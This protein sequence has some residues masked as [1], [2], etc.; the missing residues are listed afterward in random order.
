MSDNDFRAP[1]FKKGQL[2]KANELTRITDGV[3]ATPLRNNPGGLTRRNSTGQSFRPHR[4]KSS[5]GGSLV[6][7]VSPITGTYTYGAKADEPGASLTAL[8]AGVFYLSTPWNTRVTAPESLYGYWNKK[9]DNYYMP[10][11]SFYV[12]PG[13][14][15][16][17]TAGVGI[18]TFTC[19]YNKKATLSLGT[20]SNFPA[21]VKLLSDGFDAANASSDSLAWF[22]G[23][24]IACSY[25]TANNIIYLDHPQF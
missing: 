13:A 7:A 24:I 14:N 17:A 18:T 8:T 3:K 6:W 1:N 2:L 21:N 12:K 23:R 19:Y 22:N 15:Y 9:G 10:V 16:S 20:N 4:Q 25:D 5:S 11:D